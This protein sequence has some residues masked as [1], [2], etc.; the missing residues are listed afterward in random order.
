MPFWLN[1]GVGIISITQQIVM[2]GTMGQLFATLL[3]AIAEF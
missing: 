1:H 3:F 2:T